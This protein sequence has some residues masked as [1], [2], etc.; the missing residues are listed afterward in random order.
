MLMM[1]AMAAKY[2]RIH[3]YQVERHHQANS[4]AEYSWRSDE[5]VLLCEYL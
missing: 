2:H 1:L 3:I 4:T 5:V